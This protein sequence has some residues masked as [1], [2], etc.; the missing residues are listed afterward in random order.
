MTK[1]VDFSDK[2]FLLSLLEENK[3]VGQMK[4]A[5]KYGVSRRRIMNALEEARQLNDRV[6]YSGVKEPAP[7]PTKKAMPIDDEFAKTIYKVVEGK[8][9]TKL[10]LMRKHKLSR[11]MVDKLYNVGMELVNNIL[12][13]KKTSSKGDVKQVAEGST[14]RS[15][16]K[17]WANMTGEEIEDIQNAVQNGDVTKSQLTREYGVS[18]YQVELFMNLSVTYDTENKIESISVDMQPLETATGGTLFEHNGTDYMCLGIVVRNG[19]RQC[20]A[21]GHS[22]DS[23]GTPDLKNTA[24]LDMKYLP[25]EQGDGENISPVFVVFQDVN[26]VIADAFRSGML[27]EHCGIAVSSAGKTISVDTASDFINSNLMVKSDIGDVHITELDHGATRRVCDGIM[28]R[29]MEEEHQEE[30]GYNARAV[31]PQSE[32]GYRTFISSSQVQITN[33]KTAEIKV[34]DSKNPLYA[35]VCDLCSQGLVEAAFNHIEGDVDV[36]EYIGKNLTWAAGDTP[37]KDEMKYNGEPFESEAVR[38]RFRL[39]AENN[40]V[41]SMIIIE[42]FV[43]KLMENPDEALRERICTIVGYGDV[44]FCEDGDLYMYK[45]VD[46]DFKDNYTHTLDNSPGAVVRME[47]SQIDP[48]PTATCCRGLHVCSLD[49]VHQMGGY[50]SSDSKIIGVKLHPKNI[51]AV[52][53][54]YGSRKIRCCEYLS[55]DDVTVKFH[56]GSLKADSVGYFMN[57]E[58][59]RSM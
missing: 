56:E 39:C 24:T 28:R 36:M 15:K 29:F 55:L 2:T 5:D 30:Q 43:N 11:Y 23:K 45:S 27:A 54:D 32:L 44:Q 14:E 41:A 47:R 9:S 31:K 22:S 57:I 17:F 16:Q 42:R 38:N 19:E 18:W 8:Q 50:S 40:D 7:E 53:R 58:Q 48:S 52:P 4:L 20:Q 12:K 10:E 26:R 13:K 37:E 49:Y 21:V 35:K 59:T 46:G 1:Q 6:E 25:L 3:T 51:V 33:V 34:I